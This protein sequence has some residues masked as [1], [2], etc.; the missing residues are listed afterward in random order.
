MLLSTDTDIERDV[1]E[2][3]ITIPLMST[4]PHFLIGF[5]SPNDNVLKYCYIKDEITVRFFTYLV[6]NSSGHKT[7]IAQVYVPGYRTI[8]C[9]TFGHLVRAVNCAVDTKKL[10]YREEGLRR[11]VSKEIAE[12]IKKYNL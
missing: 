6:T 8:V 11:P 4:D 5:D 10:G 9:Q 12:L 2:V 1:L 3:P 7:N